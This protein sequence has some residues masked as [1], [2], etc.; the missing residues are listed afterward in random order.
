MKCLNL[1]LLF[2]LF[3]SGCSSLPTQTP[4]QDSDVLTQNTSF[5][6]V[7]VQVG[8]RENNSSLIDEGQA[9]FVFNIYPMSPAME[10]G[11]KKNDIILSINNSTIHIES[12]QS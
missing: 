4:S 1:L 8:M 6:W 9:L 11:F 3:L 7:G 12:I 5:T 2:I 10:A